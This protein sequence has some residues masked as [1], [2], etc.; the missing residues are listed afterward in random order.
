MNTLSKC[1][2]DIE[3]CAS[4]LTG[5]ADLFSKIKVF[6]KF[7]SKSDQTQER[8]DPEG[9]DQLW[10]SSGRLLNRW[11]QPDICTWLL[12]SCPGS[13]IPTPCTDNLQKM[14]D[15]LQEPIDNLQEPLENLQEPLDNLQELVDNLQEPIDNLQELLTATLEFQTKW[16][17]P[18]PPTTLTNPTA[19]ATL[20]TLTTL[21]TRST[22]TKNIP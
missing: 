4:P 5:W 7:F 2:E 22:L 21:T 15:N 3:T 6:F 19:T 8:N 14:V 13:S 20:T 10:E 17:W 11:P 1:Q 12:F 16:P 18:W 9:G